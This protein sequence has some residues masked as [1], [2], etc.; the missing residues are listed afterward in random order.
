VEA[1]AIIDEVRGTPPRPEPGPRFEQTGPS[2]YRRVQ[3]T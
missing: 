2:S 1:R 3:G